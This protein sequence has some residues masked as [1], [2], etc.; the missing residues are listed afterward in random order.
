MSVY[1][2][3]GITWQPRVVCRTGSISKPQIP[4]LWPQI[5]E[6]LHGGFM[7]ADRGGSSNHLFP[8]SNIMAWGRSKEEWQKQRRWISS[9]R[10]PASAST[11]NPFG[12][13]ESHL[14]WVLISHS[15]AVVTWYTLKLHCMLCSCDTDQCRWRR[16]TELQ[17]GVAPTQSSSVWPFGSRHHD[18]FTKPANRINLLPFLKY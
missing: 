2:Q 5:P 4:D 12:I 13:N 8:D 15:F 6:E 16:P 17:V 9:G 18:N 14:N 7:D 10:L 1:C 3:H 11:F